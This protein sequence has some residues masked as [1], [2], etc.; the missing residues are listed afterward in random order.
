MITRVYIITP[1]LAEDGK[2]RMVRLVRATHPSNALRH[3][4]SATLNVAVASQQD[5]IACLAD[6]I[7]VEDVR[8][9]QREL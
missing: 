6:G 7:K 9:E 3:V 5:L 1:K 4:A 2:P 8:P